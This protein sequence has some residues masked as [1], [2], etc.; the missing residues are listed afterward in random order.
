MVITLTCASCEKQT[1][2]SLDDY[3]QEF[4]LDID[5]RKG[6]FIFNCPECGY[7]NEMSYMPDAIVKKYNSLPR[8]RSMKG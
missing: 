6:L 3:T 7:V 1:V 4:N 5:F 2:S 8:I